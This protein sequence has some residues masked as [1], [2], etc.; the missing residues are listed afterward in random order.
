MTKQLSALEEDYNNTGILNKEHYEI[1]DQ[2]LHQSVMDAETSLPKVPKA[3]W[4]PEIG[5]KFRLLQYWRAKLSFARNK[6][7]GTMEL[8]LLKKQLPDEINIFQGDKKRGIRAQVRKA[9]KELRKARSNSFNKQQDH[10][11][12]KALLAV[13]EEDAVFQNVKVAKIVKRMKN[14]EQSCKMYRV[15]KTYLKTGQKAAFSHVD[16]PDFSKMWLAL[17][18]MM[19]VIYSTRGRWGW[20]FVFTVSTWIH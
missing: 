8:G 12:K 19:G 5:H 15:F 17:L 16:I 9:A 1:V 2:D 3:W 20:I 11:E 13:H 10:L 18:A 6:M 4:T 14:K 7:E